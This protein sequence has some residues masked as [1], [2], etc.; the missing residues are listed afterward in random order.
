MYFFTSTGE[1]GKRTDES[2]EL[3]CHKEWRWMAIPTW[4]WTD[5]MWDEIHSVA[6]NERYALASHFS[7]GIHDWD[8]SDATAECNFCHLNPSDVGVRFLDITTK[9]Q[10]MEEEYY[11]A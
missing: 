9:Q 10:L 8:G 4:H 7:M 2:D 1:Y 11:Y 3:Y 6:G 5:D